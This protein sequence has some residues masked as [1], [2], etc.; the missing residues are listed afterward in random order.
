MSATMTTP[1]IAPRKAAAA[2]WGAVVVGA[3]T[4]AALHLFGP[5]S[6]ISPVSKTISVYMLT[7]V[8]W[9][10]SAAVLIAT[11]GVGLIG[12]AA[13]HITGSATGSALVRVA[14]GG[15]VLVALLDKTDWSVGDSL[16]GTVHRFAAL[17]TFLVLPVA[18]VVLVRGLARRERREV[19]VES[20][21]NGEVRISGARTRACRGCALG[22]AAVSPLWL[23][24]VIV[25]MITVGQAGQWWLAVPLGLIERGM[26]LT[27]LAALVLLAAATISAC[28]ATAT[29]SQHH[30]PRAWPR[31]IPPPTLRGSPDRETRDSCR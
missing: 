21:R 9:I 24:P 20:P 1:M 28:P 29:P 30:S 26:A 23:V 27:E 12:Y 15:L 5:G 8:G 22:F 31:S 13:V 10:F 14:V 19:R 25:A 16:S 11:V 6:H 4:I 17:V 7:S 3:G 18:I 2:G